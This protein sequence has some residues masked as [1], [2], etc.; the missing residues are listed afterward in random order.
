MLIFVH[1]G[2]FAQSAT[3][4]VMAALG[5]NGCICERFSGHAGKQRVSLP[6]GFVQILEQ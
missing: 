4:Q 2:G 1:L 3:D 6:G 5:H